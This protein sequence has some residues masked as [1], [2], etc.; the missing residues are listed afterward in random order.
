META[1]KHL[2]SYVEKSAVNADNDRIEAF[3]ELFEKRRIEYLED[4]V[5]NRK[6]NQ[7]FETNELTKLD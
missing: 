5:R 6:M 1:R 7:S 3:V 4:L 2:N